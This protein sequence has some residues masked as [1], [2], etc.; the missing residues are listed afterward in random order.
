MAMMWYRTWGAAC[1]M[2]LLAFACGKTE[3]GAGHDDGGADSS[4]GSTAGGARSTSGG[5]AAGGTSGASIGTAGNPVTMGGR[6]A[7]G[8]AS[9]AFGGEPS[10]PELAGAAPAAGAPGCN[11]YFAACGCGCCAGVAPQATCVYTDLGQDLSTIAVEDAA[12]GRDGNCAAAGC[13]VEYDYFCCTAG[14]ASNDGASYDAHRIIGDVD[15]IQLHKSATATCST[16]MLQQTFPANP[17]DPNAFPVQAPAGWK[18]ES[19]M[20]LP[21][22]SSAIGPRAIG[23]IGK[24]SLRVLND[25]CVIDA[26]LSAFFTNERREL[27]TVRFDADG[28]PIDISV[29]QCK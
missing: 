11:D 12:K 8:G 23:A 4:A 5:T 18:L 24:L 9:S 26:H 27:A 13:S 25:T 17:A 16:L 20:S 19:V 10:E 22:T 28:V 21:C 15:R 29:D 2:L 7:L 14:P 6:G 1:S 3:A